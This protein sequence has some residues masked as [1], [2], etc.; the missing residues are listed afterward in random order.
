[1]DNPDQRESFLERVRTVT[2]S[3]RHFV[4]VALG[5]SAA[6][7]L[8][9][10][11]FA[12]QC[13]GG[14]APTAT[15]APEVPTAAPPAN[16]EAPTA[17]PATAA[18]A[19][20]PSAA[21][22]GSVNISY[23]SWPVADAM[24]ELA[25]KFG[26]DSG[27]A[28]TW[29]LVDYGK[30]KDTIMADLTGKVGKYDLVLPDSYWMWE[31]AA[32]GH[33]VDL[34][35]WIGKNIK[36]ADYQPFLD[37][38]QFPGGSGKYFA[39]PFHDDPWIMAYRSDWLTDPN[40]QA[41]FKAKYNY[42]LAAPETWDK[43][44]D[45]AEFF[46]RPDKNIAG[47]ALKYKLQTEAPIGDFEGL[48]YSHGGQWVD[49][50][51]KKA[52]GTLNTD[53]GYK[54]AE[55]FVQFAKYAG[56]DWANSYDDVVVTAMTDGKLFG[57]TN[58]LGYL[59]GLTADGSAIKGKVALAVVPGIADSGGKITRGSTLGMGTAAIS[60]YSKNQEAVYELMKWMYDPANQLAWGLKGGMPLDKTA[61]EDPKYAGLSEGTKVRV[62]ALP[63]VMSIPVTTKSADF[64]N[65]GADEFSKAAA[66]TQSSKQALDNL[67][68]WMDD[69]GFA[70]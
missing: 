9:I 28:V 6:A 55:M 22:K 67:A 21:G 32:G 8:G 70:S 52:Q 38:C 65:A 18:P 44:K 40:E 33:L 57:T 68:K 37:F 60:A 17:A 24:K 2:V 48:L 14:T 29:D 43:L 63:S 50:K 47:F 62:E 13:G 7:A 56:P 3:R 16:T 12:A 25:A 42:D 27:I 36:A 58:W 54:A 30:L 26:S 46:T 49:P 64:W 11:T 66:G 59:E 23:F 41:A 51:T 39:M 10:T 69:N 5:T 61:Y 1:M 53:P 19:V 15:T 20:T 35:D 4:K 45:V 34:T 31:A